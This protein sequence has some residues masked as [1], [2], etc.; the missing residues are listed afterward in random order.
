MIKDAFTIQELAEET[1]VAVRTIRS[2]IGK[3]LMPGSGTRGRG[4]RYGAHHLDRIRA[5]H[6]L[7]RNHSLDEIR[8]ILLSSNPETIRKISGGLPPESVKKT[9]LWEKFEDSKRVF[10]QRIERAK[11]DDDLFYSAP[12]GLLFFVLERISNIKKISRETEV[13]SWYRLKITPDFEISVR[14]GYGELQLERL[15]RIADYFRSELMG[16]WK[17]K[18]GK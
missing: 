6:V 5:I 9:D 7:K 16:V 10:T 2:Y 14:G 17:Q 18:T 15:A 4:A 11:A 1:G 3:G 12:V 8:A 13:E